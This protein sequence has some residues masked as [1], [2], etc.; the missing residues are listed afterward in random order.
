MF[1]NAMRRKGWDPDERD[2]AAVV[3]IHNTVNER[4]WAQVLVWE[5]ELHPEGW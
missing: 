2:M 1:Y 3:S 5:K 4:A